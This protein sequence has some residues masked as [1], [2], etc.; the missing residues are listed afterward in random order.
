MYA[1][2]ITGPSFSFT[3]YIH[4]HLDYISYHLIKFSI[5]PDNYF[6]VF[7]LPLSLISLRLTLYP[8]P[9][10]TN[11][12]HTHYRPI[13]CLFLPDLCSS[14][15][16]SPFFSPFL[17]T[18]CCSFFLHLLPYTSILPCIHSFPSLPAL[19]YSFPFFC[20]FFTLIRIS[21][22]LFLMFSF[23]LPLSLPVFIYACFPVLPPHLP[24]LVSFS[25][26][27]FPCHSL[28]MLG[29]LSFHPPHSPPLTTL[30][31]GG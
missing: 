17:K 3:F 25:L 18:I 12:I 14:L 7:S 15:F 24:T 23:A 21:L 6:L 19:P 4:T 31:G 2:I 9:P 28:F 5:L 29:F 11:I 20:S 8:I 1:L 13:Y 22:S 10:L 26:V 27:L 30:A 16:P